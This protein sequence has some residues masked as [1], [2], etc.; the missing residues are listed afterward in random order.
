MLSKPLVCCTLA[1]RSL[2]SREV[3]LHVQ[4]L[5]GE[6][7]PEVL[8]SANTS[9]QISIFPIT[10]C[11]GGCLWAAPHCPQ[12]QHNRG[13]P[14]QN[15]ARWELWPCSTSHD[16]CTE[17]PQCLPLR[18]SPPRVPKKKKKIRLTKDPNGQIATSKFNRKL[19]GW[20]LQ[21]NPT[22]YILLQ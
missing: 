8:K 6:E 9:C 16:L 10:S 17:P 18:Q 22:F 13:T 20:V 19:C 7:L 12:S 11:G 2:T 5:L 4:K 1:W 15:L 21:S 3:P 14:V